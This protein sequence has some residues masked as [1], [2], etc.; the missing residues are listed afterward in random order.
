MISGAERLSQSS[1]VASHFPGRSASE[2]FHFEVKPVF[3]P[4]PR[5][6]H[7]PLFRW[8]GEFLYVVMKPITAKRG[9]ANMFIVA[10]RGAGL[11]LWARCAR[12]RQ[13]FPELSWHPRYHLICPGARA[14]KLSP[15]VRSRERQ[16]IQS[17]PRCR[18]QKHCTGV[19][20][21]NDN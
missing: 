13:V 18:H 5:D 20:S 9:D 15:V 11:L 6:V 10:N 19:D 16:T 3:G 1:C 12:E 17:P 7:S 8:V 2:N 14:A 4:T 21:S